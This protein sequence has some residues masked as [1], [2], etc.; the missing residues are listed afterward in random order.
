MIFSETAIEK[1]SRYIAGTF[2]V[3]FGLFFGIL[4]TI[5]FPLRIMQGQLDIRYLFSMI[6]GYFYL[7]S[8]YHVFR[9]KKNQFRIIITILVIILITQSGILL[10][11]SIK[12]SMN[13]DFVMILING[14]L[15]SLPL[16]FLLINYKFKNS[17]REVTTTQT[18]NTQES[19]YTQQYSDVVVRCLANVID[20]LVIILPVLLIFYL[21]R[22]DIKDTIVIVSSGIVYFAFMLLTEAM[23]G[24]TLGKY[25]FHIKVIMADGRPCTIKA[26]IIRNVGRIVDALPGGYLL[27]ILFIIF[28]KKKQRIGDLLAQTVVV[29]AK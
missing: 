28:T 5:A 27:G 1:F 13:L 2:L 16:I 26:S 11:N 14:V 25:I 20:Q 18:Q 12:A 24:Q 4:L 23:Y 17:I 19:V 9:N 8:A 3:I 10:Y 7:Y 29:K 6:S 15:L 21:L 22:F